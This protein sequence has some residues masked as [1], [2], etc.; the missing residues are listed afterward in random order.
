MSW[1]PYCIS[2]YFGF[3]AG[4]A[5]GVAIIVSILTIGSKLLAKGRDYE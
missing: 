1:F 2:F 3:C 5:V 4:L